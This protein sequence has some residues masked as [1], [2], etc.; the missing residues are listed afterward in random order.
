MINSQFETISSLQYRIKSLQNQLEA[1]KSGDKYKKMEDDY[2][3]MFRSEEARIHNLEVELSHAHA[4]VVD[5]RNKWCE[6]V[7]DLYTEH[8]KALVAKDREIK[9]LK[10]R[11][12]EVE[13]QRD[14]A[15]DKVS[16]QRLELYEVKTA[17]LE[18]QGK[19]LKLTAQINHDYENSSKPSSQSPNHKKIS[20][21]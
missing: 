13:R 2:K 3:S 19:N 17:L 14:E 12:I 11:I 7:D 9:S 20:N 6:V 5:V 16:S 10:D 18:E 4:R 8:T 15:L 21:S 1:F